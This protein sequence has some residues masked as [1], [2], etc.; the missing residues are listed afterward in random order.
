MFF[1]RRFSLIL[2]ILTG[3]AGLLFGQTS[4]LDSLHQL[5]DRAHSEKE[6]A[7]LAAELAW[8][9]LESDLEQAVRYSWK[10][11]EHARHCDCKELEIDG[12]YTEAVAKYYSGDN[13]AAEALAQTVVQQAERI[14]Y[15][16][17]L[18][19]AFELLGGLNEAAGNFQ[20]CLD[21]YQ[22]AAAL[23]EELENWGLLANLYTNIGA[24]FENNGQQ[25]R[26]REYYQRAK[27]IYEKEGDEEGLAFVYA[28]LATVLEDRQQALEYLLR[29]AEIH[30][31]RGNE[32]SLA[33]VYQTLGFVYGELGDYQRAK[34][35]ELK[36]LRLRQKIGEPQELAIAFLNL[37]DSYMNL[38]LLDSAE[39]CLQQALKLPPT[40]TALDIKTYIY[41]TL[42]ELAEKKGQ[43]DQAFRFMKKAAD[44][45]DS[46]HSK[47]LS[48]ELAAFE[49]RFRASERE[50]ELLRQNLELEQKAK[51]RLSALF[52]GLVV[53]LVLGIGAWTVYQRQ[54][55]K[56]R[57]AELALAKQKTEA[58]NLR[59][60]DA[61]KSKFFANIS[62]EL[63]TPLTLIM[64]PLEEAFRKAPKGPLRN[65]LELA[66]ENSQKLLQLVDQILELSR[67]DAG[68]VTLEEVEFNLDEELR[69][70]FQAFQSLAR[71]RN[72]QMDY[73][74]RL[75]KETCLRTDLNKLE[76][77][78]NNLLSNAVKFSSS[79]GFVHLSVYA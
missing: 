70:I 74:N 31:H 23:Y 13:A 8:A 41:Y 28:D 30:A 32:K 16:R 44:L 58:E 35:Y 39:W 24:L 6:R 64:A 45:K 75:P 27:A 69:R 67:L 76:R 36:A 55:H 22:R 73:L 61:M 40:R 54:M 47:E 14:G 62:H 19:T 29:A 4:V 50:K 63:R 25:D 59:Q 34:A 46:T 21:Y 68:K 26:A 17:R 43:Y 57:V 37:G 20:Q 42:G 66:Y 49:A 72:I 38:H 18:A 65:E 1:P 9:Y 2:L 52:V 3:G 5:Y 7:E 71:T 10:T 33:G 11:V 51:S 79:G 60:L 48:Q 53:L 15:K 77:I 12:I 78:L 56:Q